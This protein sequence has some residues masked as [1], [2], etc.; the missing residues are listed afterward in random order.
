[1]QNEI[2][3]KPHALHSH[4]LCVKCAKLKKNVCFVDFY[5]TDF[6]FFFGNLYLLNLKET[7]IFKWKRGSNS[8]AKHGKGLKLENIFHI[9]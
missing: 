9:L 2:E 5:I 6:C 7:R 8:Y 1:M 4:H 3:R